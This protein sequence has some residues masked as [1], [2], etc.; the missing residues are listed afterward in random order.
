MAKQGTSNQNKYI[1]FIATFVALVSATAT[2]ST[3]ACEA[4][5]GHQQQTLHRAPGG[6]QTLCEVSKCH[7]MCPQ[8]LFVI[9]MLHFKVT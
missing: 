2:S 7:E 5:S 8:G 9:V 3:A 6:E 1:V 4:T